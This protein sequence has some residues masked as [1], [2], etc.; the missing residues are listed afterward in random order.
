MK[1]VEFHYNVADKIGYSCRL[2]KK[3]LAAE[4]H[5]LVV[6][7]PT[8]LQALDAALWALGPS[9]FVPH[10]HVDSPE[11]TRQASPIWLSP[12]LPRGARHDVMLNLGADVPEGFDRAQ[13]YLEVVSTEAQDAQ[14]GR[15]RWRHYQ[16]QGIPIKRYDRQGQS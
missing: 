7:E 12:A 3:I 4:L 2:L 8:T 11:A 13:R 1:E 14:A 16:A 5:V 6:A 10:C 15:A 9:E